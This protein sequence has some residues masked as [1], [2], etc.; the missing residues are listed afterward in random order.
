[1]SV[2][3]QVSEERDGVFRM[4]DYA[5]HLYTQEGHDRRG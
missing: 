4:P 1:M 5:R 2:R 3:V